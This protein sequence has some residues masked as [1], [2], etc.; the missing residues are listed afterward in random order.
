MHGVSSMRRVVFASS[1]LTYDP[2][3]YLFAEPKDSPIPLSEIAAVRP[4]NLCGGAKLMHEEELE[5]LAL[6]PATPFTSVSARVFRA[7]GRG[8]TR[9]RLALGASVV[10]DP[11]APLLAYR[12][13]GLFDYVYAGDVADGLIRLGVSDAVGPVN[14][15]SGSARRVSELLE[16]LAARFPAMTCNEEASDIAFEAHQARALTLAGRYRVVPVD[17]P[18]RGRRHR[19]RA[20]AW[21]AVGGHEGEPMSFDA[22]FEIE[23]RPVGP[24]HPCY[25]IAEAGSNHNRD[26]G[27]ARELIDVAADAGADAVKF[28]TYTGAGLYSSKAPRFSNM[29]DERSPRELIDD[30]ALPR[31]WQRELMSHAR[32][33]GIHFFSTPFDHEA[34]D[35]LVSLGVGVLK[36]A[37]F[38][39]VD[40]QLIG[41]AARQGCR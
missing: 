6:F 23:G 22:S 25:V 21:S 35:S 27:M 5:F 9:H 32:D 38:E 30:I 34:V 17:E 11:S 19:D 14:L 29:P 18:R 16:I 31:E 15:A 20:R 13:E 40:L 3:L 8:S 7:Y 41:K 10:A 1:Y 12:V 37:S 2:A 24:G 4:R 28:Q 33:R 26:L 39:L 36:I